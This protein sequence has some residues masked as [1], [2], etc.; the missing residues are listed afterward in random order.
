MSELAITFL[1]TFLLALALLT[2]AFVLVLGF[3]GFWQ[4]ILLLSLTVSTV[5]V[6][7]TLIVDA[8]V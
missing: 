1:V 4:E 8:N 7:R 5:A 3:T 6:V 2:G